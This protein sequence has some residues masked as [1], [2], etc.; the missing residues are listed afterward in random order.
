VPDYKFMVFTNAADGRDA[1]FNGWYDEIHL[2]EVMQV[3][4]FVGATRFRIH[5]TGD[6]KPRHSYLAIYE[7]R[8]EDPAATLGELTGRAGRGEMQM[9]DA[10][11]SDV[12]TLLV[13]ELVSVEAQS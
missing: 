12:E 8:T 13:E 3:P 4:G 11:A 9:S 7:M 2:G 1:E 5:P 10:M 6:A